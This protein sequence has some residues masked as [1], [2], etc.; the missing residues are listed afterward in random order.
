[1]ITITPPDPD[2]AGNIHELEVGW[3]PDADDNESPE[4][5]ITTRNNQHRPNVGIEQFYLPEDPAMLAAVVRSI[6][7]PDRF[8]TYT[9]RT[10]VAL[11]QAAVPWMRRCGL[12]PQSQTDPLEDWQ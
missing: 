11:I 10:R 5:W 12:L 4:W 6:L 3:D 1:M 9:P 8:T 2:K 7:D